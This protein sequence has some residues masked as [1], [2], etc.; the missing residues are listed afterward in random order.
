LASNGPG[1]IGELVASMALDPCAASVTGA[2]NP[3]VGL[4]S[5]RGTGD[6]KFW[7]L[8][9][10]YHGGGVRTCNE[11]I[12][13]LREVRAQPGNP[14]NTHQTRPRVEGGLAAPNTLQTRPRVEGGLAV[15]IH[16]GAANSGW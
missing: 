10:C 3:K 12:S 6:W 15:P 1:L 8:V 2:K 11:N 13:R 16:F 7:I 5:G 9:L 4:T 14:T